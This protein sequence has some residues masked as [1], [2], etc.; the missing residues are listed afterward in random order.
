MHT[1]PNIPQ[2]GLSYG[3]MTLL[4]SL[5]ALAMCFLA[6][7]KGLKAVWLLFYIGTSFL[8]SPA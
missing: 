8:G 1:K 6:D 2:L 3:T 5:L 4:C 7:E